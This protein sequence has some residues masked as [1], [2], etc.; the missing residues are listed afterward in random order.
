MQCHEDYFRVVMSHGAHD[1]QNKMTCAMIFARAC[2][3]F[4]LT[5]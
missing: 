2:A 1:L 3:F 5:D 4:F